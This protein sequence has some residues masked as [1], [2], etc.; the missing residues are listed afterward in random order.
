MTDFVVVIPAR[1]QSTRLP[2]KPL[3]D[4][5]G[6]PMVLWVVDRARRSKAAGVIVATD[7]DEI[8]DVCR[9][10]GVDVETTSPSHASGTDRIAEVARRRDWSSD[11]I[12]V[13]VQGDEPLLPPELVDQVAGLL[14][15]DPDADIATLQ[16]PFADLEQFRSTHTAKVITDRNHNALYFSRAPIPASTG[17]RVPT[18]ARRHIGIYAYR[19]QSLCALASSAPCEIER[20]ERL[21]QLRALWLGQRIV[22]ADSC[23]A[24][25]HGV[26]TQEDLDRIRVLA[27]DAHSC[28]GRAYGE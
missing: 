3:A 28:R 13:N 23:M 24:P 21:E 20:L 4:I 1:M 19:C 18:D 12:I 11:Q 25:A 15:Q 8:A 16:T 27:A 17:A 7:S 5:C 10:D 2:G 14:Q 22:V 9:A 6:R 26:D